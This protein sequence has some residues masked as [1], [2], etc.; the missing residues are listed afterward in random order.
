[1]RR[2]GVRYESQEL[3]V[4]GLRRQVRDARVARTREAVHL[5]LLN[6]GMCRVCGCTDRQACDLGDGHAC[7]WVDQAHTLCSRPLCISTVGLARI[8]HELG[9]R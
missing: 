3:I 1:M 2:R 5:M 6:R 9:L 7:G 8:Q 4:A